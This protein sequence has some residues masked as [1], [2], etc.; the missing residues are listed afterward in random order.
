LP[1]DRLNFDI[2]RSLLLSNFIAEW[3]Y[4]RDRKVISR[5]GAAPIEIYLFI[6][7]KIV[8]FVTIG[9]SAQSSE[10]SYQFEILFASGHDM[11]GSSLGYAMDYILDIAAH[12]VENPSKFKAPS[13]LPPSPMAPKPWRMNSMLI[14]TARGEPEHFDNIPILDG[15]VKLL[16]LIPLYKKEF[17]FISKE[18]IEAFDALCAQ[19]ELSVLD[20][21]R[22]SFASK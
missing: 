12:A 10:S 1:Y 21:N 17:D 11:A 14:D 16:W 20:L 5:D 9:L 2:R 19:Q 7:K 6:D 8:R 22:E 15:N 13:L 3:G 18:G 4:P